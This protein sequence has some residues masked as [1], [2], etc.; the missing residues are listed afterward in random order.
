MSNSTDSLAAAVGAALLHH[1]WQLATAESCTGGLVGAAITAVPGASAYY[2]GGLIAYSNV[3]KE[4]LLGVPTEIL[5]AHGAVSAPCAAAMAAGGRA[6]FA[7]DVAVATTGI[8]GPGGGSADKP[9]GLVFIAVAHPA[10][11]VVERHVFPGDRLAV[12]RATVQAALR[13]L[14]AH[15]APPAP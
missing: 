4:R 13:L 2:L 9:V 14:L 8:A 12:Q 5:A 15:I 10:G 7:A 1:R 6:R 3:V 11:S